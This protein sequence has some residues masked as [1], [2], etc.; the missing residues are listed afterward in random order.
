MFWAALFTLF[1]AIPT[2]E[3]YTMPAY[4]FDNGSGATSSANYQLRG[5]T[6]TTGGNASSANYALAPGIRASTTARVPAAPTL[7]NSDNSYDR[8]TLTLNVAGFP[9][10]TKYAVAISSDNFV[11]TQYVQTD[12][13]IGTNF[14]A[15]NYQSYAAWGGASGS[16]VLGLQNGTTY[17]VKIAALQGGA[18]GSAFGPTATAATATPS[19][20]FGLSTSLTSTPPF[21]ATFSS[22]PAGA[23]T[24]ADAT[25]SALLTS[26]AERGGT[27]LVRDLNGGLSSSAKSYTISSATA[28]LTPATAGYG[29]QITAVAQ[30]SGGP[31]VALSPYNGTANNVGSLTTALQQLA[32]FNAPINNGS[33]TFALMAK[34]SNIAPA[35]TD[36]AD[37][38]T[39]TLAL[40][41]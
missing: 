40:S 25:V 16:V 36:Y 19:V 10:D 31:L 9:S 32:S 12:Q 15:S 13:T 35:A 2:S 34:A 33:L 1:A 5:A 7:T 24:T 38:V 18:T 23:V 22:L 41:F 20:T 4:G 17:K 14:A 26:N 3:T 6:G 29:A 21:V 39:V 27:I 28:D 11:T 37:T 30:A 8:L